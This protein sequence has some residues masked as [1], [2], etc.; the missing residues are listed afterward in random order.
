MKS[1]RNRHKNLSLD[2]VFEKLGK[3]AETTRLH[4]E[5]KQTSFLCDAL[6]FDGFIN[7]IVTFEKFILA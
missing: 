7:N 3:K 4:A 5:G 6:C 2:H 1:G